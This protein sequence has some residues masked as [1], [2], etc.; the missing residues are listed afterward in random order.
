MSINATVIQQL[1]DNN[2]LSDWL[3]SHGVTVLEHHDRYVSRCPFHDDTSYS[4]SIDRVEQTWKCSSCGSEGDLFSFVERQYKVSFVE[5]VKI[6]QQGL[7]DCDQR[8]QSTLQQPH[9]STHH[10]DLTKQFKIL[11]RIIEFYQKEFW[12]DKRGINYLKSIG[13]EDQ[14]SWIDFGVGFVTGKLNDMLPQDDEYQSSLRTL[15]ILNKDNRENFHEC[16]VFP[17]KDFEDQVVGI[18][19]R[20]IDKEQVSHLY[21]P[22]PK[23]GLVNR[24]AAK[25]SKTLIITASILDA[26]ILYSNGFKNVIPLY[27][28]EGW[29]DDHQKLFEVHHVQS[30]YIC[31]DSDEESIKAAYSIESKLKETQS[32]SKI[33][34][35]IL[36]LPTQSLYEYF[37][38][39][40]ACEFEQM[41]Q[42]HSA[43]SVEK[44]EVTRLRSERFYE[45]T[46]TGFIV[47]YG[48]RE[49]E[50]KGI[51]QQGTQLKATIKASLDIK[52]QGRFQITTLDL[53]SLRSREWFSK[54]VSELINERQELIREDLHHLLIRIEE[55][56]ALSQSCEKTESKL[57][58]PEEEKEAL[59]F[60]NS[61]ML[62]TEILE[63]LEAIG[64]A[65]EEINKLLAYL[66]AISR[67][68]EDPLSLLVQSRSAAGKSTLQDSILML[69]PDEDYVKYTRLTDQALFYKAEGSL[70]H[71]ILVIEELTGMGGSEYSIRS[72]QSSKHLTLATTSKDA[73]TGRMKT[74]EYKVQGPLSIML[75][76]TEVE[77]DVEME[78]RFLTI[79]IDET[80]EM[81]AKIHDKQRYQDTLEGYLSKQ[82]CEWIK[83]KHQN[84][85]RL[86]KPFLVLNPYAPYLKFPSS[87]LRARRDHKKYLNLMKTIAY[88]RQYQKKA[89]TIKVHDETRTYIEVDLIDIEQANKIADEVLGNNLDELSAPSRT[90]LHHIHQMVKAE[91]VKCGVTMNAYTFNR[92]QLREYACWS[93]W[94]VRQ[95]ITELEKLGYVYSRMGSHG[96]T[97]LYALHEN[98]SFVDHKNLSK[99][100]YLGLTDTKELEKFQFE[101]G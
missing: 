3:R 28:T 95:H 62:L 76:T 45:T 7:S 41:I 66:V 25:R 47:A 1:K 86:L 77:I 24:Q 6:V 8:C 34:V 42:Q 79:A 82:E 100:S 60:L 65:G 74:E 18:Y 44:D 17:L 61:P 54:V 90:L 73:T 58:K 56:Q 87:P 98:T 27:G 75:T 55:N 67:K 5:A 50:V 64:C 36:K 12:E 46:D 51:A 92:R 43:N 53:Y 29:I 71:K 101:K 83:S 31:F 16:L 37:H 40:K 13:V 2:N 19:G 38:K 59:Q 96:K 9:K 20:N 70:S 88:L 33:T 39:Y 22:G 85:Q 84:A 93:E 72:M 80:Q 23:K 99:R 32:L 69:V 4:L 52:R 91:S 94:Q 21:L 48:K 63:D 10:R 68:T 89:K 26:F 81:T 35:S 57:I 49:Y 30:V 78:S 97:Y 14:Q 15:G 11:N